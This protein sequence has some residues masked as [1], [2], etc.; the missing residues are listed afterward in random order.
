MHYVSPNQNGFSF[1]CDAEACVSDFMAGGGYSFSI[2]VN[3]LPGLECFCA[4][5]KTLEPRLG[6]EHVEFFPGDEQTR[7]LRESVVAI[8][9]DQPVDM[10]DVRVGEGDRPHSVNGD[11]RLTQRLR[12]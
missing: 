2:G 10:V 12:K 1:A 8:R 7:Q 6:A 5:V 9:K 3:S 4:F 11:V